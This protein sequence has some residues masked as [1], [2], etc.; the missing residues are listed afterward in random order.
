ML[1]SSPP[2]LGCTEAVG[3]GPVARLWG[4]LIGRGIHGIGAAGEPCTSTSSGI[5]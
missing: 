2:M 3:A 1:A 4:S 5:D